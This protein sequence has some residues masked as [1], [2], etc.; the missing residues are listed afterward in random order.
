M[1]F[2]NRTCISGRFIHIA[3]IRAIFLLIAFTVTP[4]LAGLDKYF[5]VLTDWTRYLAPV[6]PTALGIS[7]VMFMRMVGIIEIIAGIIVLSKP[8]VGGWIVAFWLWGIIINLLLIP[9]FFDI[10]L[11]DFGLSLGAIALARLAAYFDQ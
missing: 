6:F 3:K 2:A 9:G 5:G 8:S 7:A 4:I 11:R 1:S 10:A